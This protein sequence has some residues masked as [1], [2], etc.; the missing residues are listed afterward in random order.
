LK[1]HL[2]LTAILASDFDVHSQNKIM[3]TNNS[4]PVEREF[5]T[6]ELT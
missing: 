5:E 3:T 6:V 2:L 1:K 4:L